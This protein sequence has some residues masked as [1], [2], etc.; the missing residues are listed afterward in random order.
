[1][2]AVLRSD[3]AYQVVAL[4]SGF[5]CG[6]SG[7]TFLD[8]DSLRN[9]NLDP[10][11]ERK[12]LYQIT[13]RK[14]VES[15]VGQMTFSEFLKIT[16]FDDLETL[17]FGIY[18]QTYP[19]ATEFTVTCGKCGKPSQVQVHPMSFINVHD[20]D[21]YLFINDIVARKQKPMELLG[22]SLVH[23][24]ERILLPETKIVVDIRTPSL[25]DHLETMARYNDQTMAQSRETF[26]CMIYIDQVLVPNLQAMRA[27]GKAVYSKLE[28]FDEAFHVV[29]GLRTDGEVLNAAI[30]RRERKFAV[31]FR[32][33][34]VPCSG[35]KED[36][37]EIPI[38]VENLLYFQMEES[39][40]RAEEDPAD[41]D[42]VEEAP[43]EGQTPDQPPTSDSTTE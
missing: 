35:C 7:L 4:R 6:M 17:L 30:N 19:N 33:K 18:C 37:G 20:E 34:S 10:Y 15:S 1:M 40:R 2:E 25:E 38:D 32:I 9:S 27:S 39:R 28:N 21:V 42:P 13:H 11:N 22:Q 5:S 24:H 43:V 41:K 3:A 23:S 12:R 26:G 16:A 29:C 8:K 14:M 31:T 36:M